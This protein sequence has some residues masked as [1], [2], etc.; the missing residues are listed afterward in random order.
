MDNVEDNLVD[1]V[2]YHEDN[3][4]MFHFGG[5]INHDTVKMPHVPYGW[6]YLTRK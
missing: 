3:C 5:T 1:I 2:N 4:V 6:K